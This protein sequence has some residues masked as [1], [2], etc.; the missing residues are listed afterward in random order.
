MLKKGYNNFAVPKSVGFHYEF[1]TQQT[2]NN[3]DVSKRRLNN[4]KKFD[5]RWK[6]WLDRQ[7]KAELFTTDKLFSAKKTK[8][9]FAVTEAGE[10]VT[11]GDYFTAMEFGEAF[12][13][14]GCDVCFLERRDNKW[15]NVDADIDVIISLLEA[16][17]LNKIG[18]KNDHIIKIAW[19]RNWFERWV[20]LP[21]ID[22]FDYILASSEPACEFM[23]RTL[24]RTVHLLK[25]GTNA[26]RF[27]REIPFAEDFNSDYCFT[28]SYWNDPREIIDMLNPKELENHK[29][30]VFGA[31]WNQVEKFQ[32]Y[33]QGFVEYADMPKIYKGTK[34]V[35]DDANRVTKPFGSVNSRVFDALASGTLVLTNGIIGAEDTFGDLLPTF[36]TEEEL[37]SLLNY[38]LKN[39]V[40]RE[41]LAKKLQEIVCHYH[42]Y[43][44]RARQLIEII[45]GK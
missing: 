34:L 15:Y 37:S 26:E 27:D 10:H 20:K 30:K 29:F 7:L 14:Q 5:L 17:D 13:R 31:N 33:N 22:Q 16:F 8:I 24:N 39:E 18:D 11:A 9:A 32:D 2:Q 25:I 35:I 1:G 43:D 45:E 38:Y 36:A 40:E 28:G 6:S 4:R 21:F 23:E 42:S 41:T 12:K 19:A 3:K 44:Y